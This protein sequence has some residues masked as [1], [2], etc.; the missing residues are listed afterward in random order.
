MK[1]RPFALLSQ[2]DLHALDVKLGGAVEQWRSYTIPP[3]FVARMGAVS[4]ALDDV[5]VQ[6]INK[7]LVRRVYTHQGGQCLLGI[8][9]G[10]FQ[11]FCLMLIDRELAVTTNLIAPRTIL[12]GA[13]EEVLTNLAIRLLGGS[14]DDQYVVEKDAGS[15]LEESKACGSG[16]IH[17]NLELEQVRFFIAL[18][19]E[20]VSALLMKRPYHTEQNISLSSRKDAIGRITTHLQAEL[21]DIQLSLGVLMS[22]QEGDVIK[23]EH[24]VRDP[25]V[26]RFQ[27]AA[28]ELTGYLGARD[29]MRAVSVTGARNTLI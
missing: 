17:F 27:G 4:T 28:T 8:T 9:P 29:G 13:A 20:A 1:V 2:R 10:M 3:R 21:G 15:L 16:Y 24:R 5:Q 6:S 25:M 11:A 22:L 7:M 19:H 12:F 14:H 23:T 26:V 18:T